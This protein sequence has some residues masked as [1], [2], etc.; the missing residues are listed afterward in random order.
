MLR[1]QAAPLLPTPAIAPL[2]PQ[3]SPPL[4]PSYGPP[5]SPSPA[6]PSLS[7]LQPHAPPLSARPQ[8]REVQDCESDSFLGCFKKISYKKGGVKS[9]FRKAA[10]LTAAA[11]PRPPPTPPPWAPLA[12]ASAAAAAAPSPSRHCRLLTPRGDAGGAGRVR[13]ALAAR[14]GHDGRPRRRCLWR[15]AV[16]LSLCSCA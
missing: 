16:T 12:T 1:P 8:H 6:S 3:L 13:D 11:P 7:L 5:P 14:Q 4:S 15:S 10:S 2:P 9:G